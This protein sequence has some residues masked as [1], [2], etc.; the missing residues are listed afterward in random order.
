MRERYYLPRDYL[1]YDT[2]EYALCPVD[3]LYPLCILFCCS[4]EMAGGIGN[5]EGGSTSGPGVGV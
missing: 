1:L 3:L 2:R 4:L 5:E